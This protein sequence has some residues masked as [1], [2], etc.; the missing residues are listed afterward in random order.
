MDEQTARPPQDRPVTADG[1]DRPK[2]ASD[3]TPPPPY[4]KRGRVALIV[5][6]S[7]VGHIA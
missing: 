7:A 5:G 4:K 2:K 6:V 1:A 3:S